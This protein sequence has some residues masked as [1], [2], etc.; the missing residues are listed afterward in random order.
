MPDLTTLTTKALQLD[1]LRSIR[2]CASKSF[3]A[4]RKQKEKMKR[5]MQGMQRGQQLQYQSTGYD[6]RVNGHS[7][8]SGSNGRGQTFYQNSQ[9]LANLL[10]SI[11]VV[12]QLQITLK[13]N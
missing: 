13:Q 5:M 11:T 8:F 9:S 3:E 4:L 12:I 1:A 7:T 10:L 2:A 6:D